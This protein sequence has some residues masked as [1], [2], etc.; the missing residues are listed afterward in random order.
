MNLYLFLHVQNY[1][2]DLVSKFRPQFNNKYSV[3]L[4]EI[5]AWQPE[6]LFTSQL[7]L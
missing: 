6:K 4:Y 3:H 5:L 2:A 7:A 1:I